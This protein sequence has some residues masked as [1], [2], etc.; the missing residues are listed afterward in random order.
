MY[1]YYMV[2]VLRGRVHHQGPGFPWAQVVDS[3]WMAG[4]LLTL[5]LFVVKRTGSQA[6]FSPFYTNTMCPNLQVAGSS[7]SILEF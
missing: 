6:F 5:S 1:Y 7:G 2:M 4:W 3:D